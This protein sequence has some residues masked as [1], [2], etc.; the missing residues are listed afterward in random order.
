MSDYFIHIYILVYSLVSEALGPPRSLIVYPAKMISKII[1]QA[2]MTCLSPCYQIQYSRWCSS[3]KIFL[4]IKLRFTL[5]PWLLPQ[6]HNIN[7][8]QPCNTCMN[9]LPK[10]N[11]E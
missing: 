4:Q 1:Q 5:I 6:F 11:W 3:I 7:W 9:K 10:T 2:M 8:K